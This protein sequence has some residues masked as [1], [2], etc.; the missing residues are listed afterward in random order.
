[1]S[2][3]TAAE[4]ASP[5]LNCSRNSTAGPRSF[6]PDIML[7]VSSFDLQTAWF[8]A[9]LMVIG[10]LI[11]TGILW[12]VRS[13][14]LRRAEELL[15]GERDMARELRENR[16][17]FR[18][19]M[20]VAR[21]ET[22]NWNLKTDEVEASPGLSSMFGGPTVQD[23]ERE[24]DYNEFI[25]TADRDRVN[26][27][28]REAVAG[29]GEFQ[30]EFRVVW[31]DGTE[32]WIEGRGLLFRD[33]TGEAE[34]LLGV[35][36]D[37]TDRR[38]QEAARRK[39]DGHI[40][41]TQRYK[42]LGVMAGGIAHDFNNLL[43]SIMA[44]VDIVRGELPKHGEHREILQDAMDSS[45]RAAELCGQM[46]AY[47]GGGKYMLE[48]MN[49][50]Q[51]VQALHPLLA[52]SIDKNVV[53]DLDL[54]AG[55]PE[56][57][58]DARQMRQVIMN[59]VANASEAM[60]GESG[61]VVLRTAKVPDGDTRMFTDELD[62]PLPPGSYVSLQVTDSG[63]GM[64]ADQLRRIFDPFYTTRFTGR[65]LGLAA[66]RGIIRGHRGGILVKSVPSHGTTFSIAIPVAGEVPS[67]TTDSV[68]V[69]QSDAMKGKL[70]LVVEDESDVR[71][72]TERVLRQLGYNVMTAADGE[73]GVEF[74][75]AQHRRLT[76]VL[77]DLTMPGMDGVETLRSMKG[78][79]PDVPVILMSGYN[80]R[81]A[82]SRFHGDGLAGFV[83]KPFTA[84]ILAKH[85]AKART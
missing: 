44:N 17:R 43:T 42:S 34:S 78:I 22:W 31:R 60:Q 47:S 20:E 52:A 81:E 54:R 85:I 71:R 36:L 29:K 32:R 24:P 10:L 33:A 35:S 7:A 9:S 46:L 30:H 51:V 16:D 15:A 5:L 40:Q 61:R 11:V 48:R 69:F 55:L 37:I 38:Q 84:E 21:L 70:I 79:A 77:L 3:S 75:R 74:F 83:K 73:E 8:F 25:H 68:P 39:L 72:T 53:L 14:Q 45:H 67:L 49:L 80:E 65:G 63:E 2:N 64:T 41:E 28:I 62:I 57:S 59:L 76:L 26:S 12:Q 19:A 82:L 6:E 1:M 58:A 50:N 27:A 4:S 13:R 56:V 18:L 23:L 66:V